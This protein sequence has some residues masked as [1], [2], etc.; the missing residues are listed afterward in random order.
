MTLVLQAL[1]HKTLDVSVLENQAGL[2]LRRVT[3]QHLPLSVKER[4]V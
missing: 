3:T 2:C 1:L 4:E